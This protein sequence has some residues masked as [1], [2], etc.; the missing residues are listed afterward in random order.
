MIVRRIAFFALVVF[1]SIAG[2][3]AQTSETERLNAWF[4]QKFEEQLDFS[5]MMKTALGRKDDYDRLDDVS[6]AA[7][8]EQL[9]WLRASVRELRESFD[10]ELLASEAQTSW[11]LWVYE[12]ERAEA[13]RPF[14]RRSYLFHQMGGAHTQLPQFLINFHRVDDESD[15]RA[16]LSRLREAARMLRQTLERAELA[17]AE[18]VHAPRFSYEAVISQSSAVVTGH[19][20]DQS[21]DAPPSPLWA[22]FEAK[23]AG[24]VDAGE[25]DEAQ[26]DELKAEAV[27]ALRGAFGPAYD[28]LI[29]WAE[30]ELPRTEAVATGVWMLPDGEAYYRER[31][32]ANTTTDM[33]ADEIHVLGLAEVARIQDE[34][35]EVMDEVGFDGSL[36][37]FFVFFRTDPQFVYPSTDEGREDYLQAARD[38]LEAIEDRLPEY[39]GLLPKAGLE[40]RRV[41]S[42]REEP[43]AAQ[44]YVQGTPDGSRPGVY[45]AHL[46][47]MSSMPIPDLEVVAYHEGLP[48][49]HMQIAIAQ[50]LEGVPT[51]RTQIG[52][53][54]YIEGWALYSE[55]LARE[56][57]AY[58]DPYSNFGALSAEIWRAIRLVV[59][60]GLHAMGWTQEEAVQYFTDNSPVSEGQIRSEI[61]RYIVMPGQ[62]TGYKIGMIRIQELRGRAEAELGDDFDIRGFHDTV[63]GGGALPL[64][65]LEQRVEDWIE[66]RK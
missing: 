63:L 37:E 31:L 43:G 45:Y 1:A 29:A 33:T 54:A 50:E 36:D 60:T 61:E 8:D 23:L 11:D 9:E 57:G 49:H 21:A 65:I 27:E 44:H 55:S 18:G 20:F 4:E 53:N 47:D 15:M 35:R 25:I 56:M 19:P 52:F 34:M 7:L 26:A 22:D 2:A 48:G 39:F 38:H 58:E 16:Y 59:D 46:I 64:S 17:A 14:R 3:H 42:F 62:A 12:L 28:A 41:E 24:L 40:V 10:Y 13:A 5:P 66:A 32:A 51:F 30:S 6:E